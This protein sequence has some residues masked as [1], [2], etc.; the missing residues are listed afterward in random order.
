MFVKSLWSRTAEV[1]VT[2]QPAVQTGCVC[3]FHWELQYKGSTTRWLQIAIKKNEKKMLKKLPWVKLSA[4][5]KSMYLEW[6]CMFSFQRGEQYFFRLFDSRLDKLCLFLKI[7]SSVFVRHF[8]LE[9]FWRNKQVWFFVIFPLSVAVTWGSS[10]RS[11]LFSISIPIELCSRPP[12]GGSRAP[13]ARRYS[14]QLFKTE[15]KCIAAGFNVPVQEKKFSTSPS[16]T[17]GGALPRQGSH[18]ASWKPWQWLIHFPVM[19]II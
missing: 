4:N 2:Q 1:V 5:R 16:L 11:R 18:T 19:E 12:P 8:V 10:D 13:P 9:S 7:L 14:Q 6:L 3:G 17:H 15:L